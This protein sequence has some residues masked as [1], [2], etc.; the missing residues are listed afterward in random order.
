MKFLLSVLAL[1]WSM[2]LS[3]C[4]SPKVLEG[5]LLQRP[6]NRIQSLLIDTAG[7]NAP[8][9]SNE[10]SNRIR[11][12]FRAAAPVAFSRYGVNAQVLELK[13]ELAMHQPAPGDFVL[14]VR[15]TDGFMYRGSAEATYRLELYDFRSRARIWSGKITIAWSGSVAVKNLGE[16]I[17]NNIAESMNASRL[18][19]DDIVRAKTAAPGAAR[20]KPVLTGKA[21]EAFDVYKTLGSPKAFVL[22]EGGNFVYESG[23]AAG[24]DPPANRALASCETLHYVNCRVIAEGDQVL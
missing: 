13:N 8:Y 15:F 5:T 4:V 22:G 16:V 1:S 12:D 9:S 6:S 23:R 21:R 3:G 2:L 14:V 18:F 24:E 20:S 10:W 17:A 19:G 7:A 11:P